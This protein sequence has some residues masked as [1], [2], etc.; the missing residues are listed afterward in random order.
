LNKSIK[1]V[2]KGRGKKPRQNHQR[3]MEELCR[4]DEGRLP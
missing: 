1:I 3:R 2:K 4:E